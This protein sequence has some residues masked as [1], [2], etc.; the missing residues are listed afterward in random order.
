M[1]G[2]V[3]GYLGDLVRDA[4]GS[5][6]GLTYRLGSRCHGVPV[7]CVVV[8]P[9]LVVVGVSGPV[10]DAV[11][12]IVVS[13]EA[14]VLDYV[15]DDVFCADLFVSFVAVAEV[16]IIEGL[17]AVEGLVAGAEVVLSSVADGSGEAVS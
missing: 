2:G 14:G 13:G 7:A 9:A 5:G 16:K 3:A 6:F 12:C 17:G 8:V 15:S 10:G 11:S 1:G 4:V